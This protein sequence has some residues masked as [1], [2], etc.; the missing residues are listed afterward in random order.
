[1][2]QILIKTNILIYLIIIR[3]HFII[4]NLLKKLIVVKKVFLHK[5]NIRKAKKICNNYNLNNNKMIKK[6]NKINLTITPIIRLKNQ[7]YQILEILILIFLFLIKRIDLKNLKLINILN[8]KIPIIKIK[9]NLLIK[10]SKCKHSMIII[11]MIKQE[12]SN[13]H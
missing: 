6:K 11:N 5:I 8:S 4:N 7:L 1:M 3:G 10:P 9:Y 13:F 2:I 12:I